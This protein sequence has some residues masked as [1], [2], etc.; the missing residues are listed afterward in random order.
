MLK[1]KEGEHQHFD[2][3]SDTAITSDC[4]SELP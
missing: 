1:E 4:W 2:S 3:Y